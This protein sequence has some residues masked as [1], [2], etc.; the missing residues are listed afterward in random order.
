MKMF[1]LHH[2]INPDKNVFFSLS[3]RSE[4]LESITS[5]FNNNTYYNAQTMILP[6]MQ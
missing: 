1:S 2:G 4:T 5:R 3:A 6:A